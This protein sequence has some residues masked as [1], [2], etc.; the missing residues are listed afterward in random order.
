MFKLSF[1]IILALLT[2]TATSVVSQSIPQFASFPAA[3]SS[4]C[5]SVI[6]PSVLCYQQYTTGQDIVSCFCNGLAAESDMSTCST[7]LSSNG[8]EEL[9]GVLGAIPSACSSY[10]QTCQ[11]ECAFNT[12]PS[13]DVA[14]QCS[15][16]YL[17]NIYQCASCNTRNNN[18]GATQVT[19]YESLANSCGNQN[20]TV[21]AT[22]S[23]ALPSPTGQ[24]SYTAP[25]LAASA[26]SYSAGTA[27]VTGFDISTN[28]AAS[29]NTIG[30]IPVGTAS[31]SVINDG[32]TNLGPSRTGT[33]I[34]DPTTAAAGTSAS[35]KPVASS[36]ASSAKP[37]VSSGSSK[38]TSAA[39]T[40]TS[41]SSALSLNVN[42][43]GAV[44]ALFA[45][46]ALF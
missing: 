36:G 20:Y 9:S 11:K 17:A 30:V 44:G 5:A 7:C 35:A 4:Q 37:A 31:P 16:T 43:V 3:C 46:I 39:A 8:Q 18:V 41:T 28:G 27:T 6:Q 2:A 10:Q 24:S 12:C 32:N 22:S 19:D 45:A 15:Q 33:L 13:S 25:T 38:S 1:T 29:S 34:F 40:A 21:P 14:C 23:S 26:S 42:S